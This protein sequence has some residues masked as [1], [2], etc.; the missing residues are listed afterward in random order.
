MSSAD[1]MDLETGHPCRRGMVGAVLAGAVAAV[2]L[3]ALPSVAQEVVPEGTTV[4]APY[5]PVPPM[6]GV[7]PPQFKVPGEMVSPQETS[8]A[9]AAVTPGMTPTLPAE[10]SG[11]VDPLPA[12]TSPTAA[13]AS[14]L[15]PVVN[16]VLA[17]APPA[18]VLTVSAPQAVAPV[19]APAVQ[20]ETKPEPA[21]GA[22]VPAPSPGGAAASEAPPPSTEEILRL[23]RRPNA[24]PLTISQMAA[25]NDAITRAEYVAQ[26]EKK[27]AEMNLAV[28]TG[29]GA[30]VAPAPVTALSLPDRREPRRGGDL[31]SGE[32]VQ[33]RVL[34][35][36]G[37]R[38]HYAALVV[39]DGAQALVQP[40]DMVGDL[41]IASVAVSGV[42]ATTQAG[43]VVTLSFVAPAGF[44][45][46]SA[47]VGVR[48]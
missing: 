41:R 1:K 23:L 21:E 15:P 6:P 32:E 38:G 19:T 4:T 39:V 31:R 10:S 43:D 7:V 16:G 37:A 40:G 24:Q 45:G 48:R 28:A 47:T 14:A 2:F 33:P 35:V 25:V 22:P 18:T 20:G 36:L 5:P 13:T 27:M 12:S 11:G 17:L 44:E 26:I 29:D 8:D 3:L 34:R 30:A 42:R 9:S 46:V